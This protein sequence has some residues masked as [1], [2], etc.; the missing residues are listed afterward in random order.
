MYEGRPKCSFRNVFS[1]EWM[2][3]N[4]NNYFLLIHKYANSMP[5]M[6]GSMPTT[7]N[8]TKINFSLDNYEFL[9]EVAGVSGSQ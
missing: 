3:L 8:I 1:Q 5:T 9:C 2:D 7:W 6:F 4:A